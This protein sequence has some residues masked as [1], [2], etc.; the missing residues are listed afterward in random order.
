MTEP[1]I[2]APSLL[3]QSYPSNESNYEDCTVK[4]I[5]VEGGP[6]TYIVGDHT[7]T[8]MVCESDNHQLNLWVDH[9]EPQWI[10]FELKLDRFQFWRSGIDLTSKIDFSGWYTEE[11]AETGNT[12]KLKISATETYT[13]KDI[14]ND[15]AEDKELK[16]AYKANDEKYV[17][18]VNFDGTKEAVTEFRKLVKSLQNSNTED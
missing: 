6:Y 17:D 15:L 8:E 12:E 2:I 4:D 14:L 16:F 9:S 7:K 5:T 13:L 11:N 10:D 3:P 18:T 1:I